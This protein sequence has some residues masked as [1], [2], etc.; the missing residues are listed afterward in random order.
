[1]LTKKLGLNHS[2]NSCY[3]IDSTQSSKTHK[4][5]KGYIAV[6]VG[7][8]RKRYEVGV[9]YLSLPEFQELIV[10]SHADE[11]EPKIEGPLMLACRTEEFDQLLKLAKVSSGKPI[12]NPRNLFSCT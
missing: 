6:Y 2:K 9:K 10:Q 8:E 7:E 12:H 1:M 3:R 5:P 4:V 11:I